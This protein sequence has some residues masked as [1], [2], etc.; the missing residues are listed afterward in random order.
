MDF[1]LLAGLLLGFAI[2]LGCR[3]LAVPVPAPQAL[4][5]ALLVVAMTSGYLLADRYLARQPARRADD[6]GGPAGHGHRGYRR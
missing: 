2:G 5:G 6:C 3:A 1:K 4:V